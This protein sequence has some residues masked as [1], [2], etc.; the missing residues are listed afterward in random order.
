MAQVSPPTEQIGRKYTQ[1]EALALDAS[2]PLHHLRSEFIIPTKGDLSRGTLSKKD[3][4]HASEDEPCI[5]LCGNSLGLQPGRTAD[6]IAAHL[7]A[8]ATKGVFGHF[9]DH[10]DSKLP[11]FLHTD[12][13]AAQHVAPLVGASASE[14]AIMETLSANLHLMMASF[15]RPTEA[16]Y[17]IILEGKAFPSDHVSIPLRE[18]KFLYLIFVKYAVESQIRHHGLK[19]EDAMILIEPSDQTETTISTSHIFSMIKKHASDTAL[20]LLPGVQYY[21]GQYFDIPA[22]TACAHS[23]DIPIGWDL[24]HAVGN[25]ELYLHDWGV[26]FAVWCSYKYLN[27]GPGA[28]AGLFVHEKHGQ[29]NEDATSSGTVEYRP[30]LSGWWGG[31]KATRFQM[32]NKFVPIPGAAGFQLGNPCALAFC[33]LLASLEIFELT[34]MSAVR[35]KSIMLTTYLEEL[36]GRSDSEDSA[37]D[38]A[39]LYRILTPASSAE[40]GAQL[41]ILLRPGLLEAVM[42]DL[43]EHGVVVDERKPDVVRVAPAPLYNTF[44]DVWEFVNI[45]KRACVKAETGST[46]STRDGEG[47]SAMAGQS[48][49][50]WWQIK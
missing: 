7:E 47:Y 28:I 9:K 46:P 35:G 13:V 14:V 3:R 45:F 26:D 6:R 2:D 21:T 22:I 17:K 19:P 20:V 10:K 43:E 24:A 33:P 30:R 1:E 48:D 11:A 12:D 32:G 4:S 44:S 29:V 38:A 40:R 42:V 16:K 18:R 31:D 8:W 36:L 27:S 15:Y 5:Y 23:H 25:V 37:K 49:K 50:G 39:S 41:S 34:S